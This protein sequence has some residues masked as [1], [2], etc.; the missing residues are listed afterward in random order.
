MK[1]NMGDADRFIRILIAAVVAALFF[2]EVVTGTLGTVLMVIG[3]VFLLTE[4]V[5]FCPLYAPFG[6]KTCKT[7]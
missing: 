6:L 7:R 3:G 1:I 4:I 2:A 5:G